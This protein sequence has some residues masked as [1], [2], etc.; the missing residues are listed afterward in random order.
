MHRAHVVLV[1]RFDNPIGT[2]EKMAAHVAGL[3]H[4]AF[5]VFVV[6]RS[7]PVPEI[8]LQRRA[9][10]K[11]HFGGLWSNTCC[12]HPGPG[13]DTVAAGER[14]LAEE[15]GIRCALERVGEFIYRAEASNG[16]YEH[17]LDHVL[18]GTSEAD[19]ILNASEV[20]ASR[21]ITV[22]DLEAELA[23]RPT[24]FTPWLP[25]A[26][27]VAVRSP[28]VFTPLRRRGGEAG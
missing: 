17:E 20:D 8:L 14:R 22:A 21:W 5:S 27:E 9:P 6:R 3:L 4:R 1:D 16:L 7:G 15:M 10:S 19:P 23:S 24:S 28:V 13:A 18:V 11:Y 25:G 2:E 12:G 26:L